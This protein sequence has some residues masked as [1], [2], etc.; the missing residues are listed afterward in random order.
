MKRRAG[1]GLPWSDKLYDNSGR[2]LSD[3]GPEEEPYTGQIFLHNHD[4]RSQ[5]VAEREPIIFLHECTRDD[6]NRYLFDG[7][8][9]RLSVLDEATGLWTDLAT[10]KGAYSSR[11]KAAQLQNVLYFT[12]DVDN[13]LSLDLSALD[14]FTTVAA[15]MSEITELKT[16]MKI[17]AAKVI[18]QYQGF[19]VLMNVV[20]DGE[21]HSTRVAWSN[22]NDG[23]DWDPAA[24][25]PLTGFQDLTYGDD[26]LG[27]AQMH[28]Q[29]YIYT[30]RGIWK[31]WPSS[32][33]TTVFLFSQIYSEP[34]NQKGCLFYPETLISTGSEHWYMSR[35]SICR[36]DPYIPA[37]EIPDWLDM[38]SPPIFSTLDTAM[39]GTQ[40]ALPV[41]CMVP[42][43]DEIWFSWPTG[44]LT[45]NN[46]TL[47]ASYAQKTADLVDAGFTAFCNYRRTPTAP[48][49]CNEVQSLFGASGTDY[50]IKE[51]GKVFYREYLPVVGDGVLGDP[52]E[53][54]VL[55][56]YVTY[57]YKSILRAEI[58]LGFYDR[59]KIVRRVQLDK[60]ASEETAAPVFRLRIGNAPNSVDPNSEDASCSP[61]WSSY[62]NRA[63]SCPETSSNTH[64]ASHKQK[65]SRDTKW[66]TFRKA[67][68]LYFELV[69]ADANGVAAQGGN[70]ELYKFDFDATAM[71]KPKP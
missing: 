58:P 41:A 43:K 40:C 20:Y 67:K 70:V 27:A 62:E 51:I 31:M 64:L 7:T 65:P 60:S 35:D 13:I 39:S 14:D 6:G 57:G 36:F 12:N 47:V 9:S 68:H 17:T 2:L 8:K 54:F 33:E 29:V 11:W 38:A 44:N 19:L 21:R 30:R 61:Q 3:Y 49:L 28:G 50:C 24:V 16:L 34:L 46:W 15:A 32:D 66:N 71:P 42:S 55:G 22:Q 37:P 53:V 4:H 63:I 25:E 26:I 48:G 1:F 18:I 45:V 69:I 59:E 23:M 10:G 52:S 5:G 56:E